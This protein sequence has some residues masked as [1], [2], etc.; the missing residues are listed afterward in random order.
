MSERVG[1]RRTAWLIAIAGIVAAFFCTPHKIAHAA[2][3]ACPSSL[4]G[5]IAFAGTNGLILCRSG[6]PPVIVTQRTDATALAFLHDAGQLE[7]RSGGALHIYDIATHKNQIVRDDAPHC[8]APLPICSRSQRSPDGRWLLQAKETK[9]RDGMPGSTTLLARNGALRVQV[10]AR[11][12]DDLDLAGIAPDGETALFWIDPQHSASLMSDTVPL[13]MIA[14]SAVR[15][16]VSVQLPATAPP[17]VA[18]FPVIGYPLR[19]W[20]SFAPYGG[21]FAAIAGETREIFNTEHLVRCTVRQMECQQW[22]H[23]PGFVEVDPA[24]SPSAEYIAFVR[25]VELHRAHAPTT[26]AAWRD[27][28]DTRRLVL[29]SADPEKTP[30]TVNEAGSDISWPTWISANRLL[31]ISHNRLREFDIDSRRVRDLA[32]LADRGIGY[33]GYVARSDRFAWNA[34]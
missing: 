13:G 14:L 9:L 19:D 33:Y 25:G 28:N 7:F 8:P 1:I 32:N 5:S 30:V 12:G 10:H 17:I 24:W 11:D 34:L 18:L 21:A 15:H 6:R 26:A 4:P 16:N 3:V 2:P 22:N 29:A 23:K 27:W 20:I 31:F